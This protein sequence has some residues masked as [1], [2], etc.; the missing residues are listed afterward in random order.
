MNS[1]KLTPLAL[2][3]TS[4]PA[5]TARRRSP[6]LTTSVA[7]ASAQNAV[8]TTRSAQTNALGCSVD[9]ASFK[10][11]QRS[12]DSIDPLSFGGQDSYRRRI[13]E[14]QRRTGLTDGIMTGTA[15]IHGQQVVIAVVD[16]RFM[17]GSLG[18][19]V[20][21][22]LTLALELLPSESYRPLLW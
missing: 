21:E 6:L 12:L 20:G 7:L 15:S 2:N 14:E 11:T 5:S 3:I 13:F 4:I 16:F 8:F 19:V 1:G 9:E 10:E 18:C 17:G 22:R